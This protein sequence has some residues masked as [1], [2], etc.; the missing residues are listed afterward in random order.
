MSNNSD[1]TFITNEKGQNLLERFKV[2]IKDT[3][4]FVNV[5]TMIEP[6]LG[7]FVELKSRTW[8]KKDAIS[9]SKLILELIKHLGLSPTEVVT[10]DYIHIV[11]N[12][13]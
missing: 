11:K 10:E 8:G 2:L 5:D 6:A 4:F 12:H 13:I 7:H 1:L 3:E 9:K